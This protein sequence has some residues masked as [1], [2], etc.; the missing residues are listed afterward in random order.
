MKKVFNI[1]AIVVFIVVWASFAFKV[2]QYYRNVE[3]QQEQTAE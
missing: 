1:I 3:Q 2:E